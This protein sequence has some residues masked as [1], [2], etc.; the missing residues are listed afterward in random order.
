MLANQ[1]GT[2]IVWGWL[3]SFSV[4]TSL[5]HY[6]FSLLSSLLP[7]TKSNKIHLNKERLYCDPVTMKVTMKVIASEAAMEFF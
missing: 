7:V 4:A 6:I 2:D 1:I 5:H 3:V